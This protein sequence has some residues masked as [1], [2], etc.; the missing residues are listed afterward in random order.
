MVII[1]V[2]NPIILHSSV[3]LLITK[4]L[5][6]KVQEIPNKNLNFFSFSAHVTYGEGCTSLTA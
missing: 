6:Q 1:A 4:T 3:S 5:D 2:R